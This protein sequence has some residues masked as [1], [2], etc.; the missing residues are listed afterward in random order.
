MTISFNLS[1]HSQAPLDAS[2]VQR[3]MDAFDTSNL[4]EKQIHIIDRIKEVSFQ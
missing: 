1:T 4:G 3:L 2:Q